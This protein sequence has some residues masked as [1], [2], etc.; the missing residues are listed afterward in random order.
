MKK[1]EITF[2]VEELLGKKVVLDTPEKHSKDANYVIHSDGQTE[3]VK[4]SKD[5]YILIDTLI[6][7]AHPK[8]YLHQEQ[9]LIDLLIKIRE[10]G[11]GSLQYTEH[12]V[13][14]TKQVLDSVRQYFTSKG[15]RG[16]GIDINL[17]VGKHKHQTVVTTRKGKQVVTVKD[18]QNPYTQAR[19]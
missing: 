19:Y 3:E 1:K 4:P 9:T 14:R 8:L 5:H 18:G 10:A 16:F 11:A 13:I 7:K 15:L 12:H 17:Y 6:T 2:K